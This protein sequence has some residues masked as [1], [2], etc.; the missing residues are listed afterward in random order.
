[1]QLCLMIEGQ[2][3]VSWP[4]WLALAEACERHGVPALFR[5]DHYMNLDLEHPERAALDAWGTTCAL[6]A[7]TSKLELGTL[8]SPATFRHPSNLA[9]LVVTADH[10]SGGRVT[11]GVGAGW[12]ER[13]H[14]AYGFEFAD[15]Q[16][17]MDVLEEQ[18]Q[19]V[20]G[21]WGDGRF[22]FTGRHYTLKDLQAEPKPVRRPHPPLIIGGSGGPRS[23]KL[24]ATYAD[25]YNTPFP[26]VRNVSERRERVD[27]ACEQAGRER[28][29]FSIMTSRRGR[30]RRTRAAGARGAARREDGRRARR[31]A[32]GSAPRLG[33][34]HRRSGNR[35]TAR[36]T[37]C[38]RR[39]RH[40]PAAA[41]R[42]P[43]GGRAAGRGAGAAGYLT[44]CAPDVCCTDTV[45]DCAVTTGAPTRWTWP[46]AG[47][48]CERA[49]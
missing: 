16:T 40:V 15:T 6:A 7:V 12:H 30:R 20:L 19:I 11:L 9:K 21:N 37:R 24:A 22:S 49:D 34:R 42:R 3:G 8:V 4:Q 17:R 47:R 28:L 35:A 2:E 31:A 43:R 26:S 39:A 5:S 27:R 1:M 14:E 33:R 41:A 38:R 36:V 48:H 18:V 32:V 46:A 25:E 13:E 10:V 23:A 29:P 44:I 45:A